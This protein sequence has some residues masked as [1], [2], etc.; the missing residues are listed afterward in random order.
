M[1]TAPSQ[2]CRAWLTSPW[3]PAG[4]LVL[5]AL[6]LWGPAVAYDFINYDDNLYVYENPFVLGGL[7]SQGWSYAWRA[8][9]GGS[10]MPLTWLSL[11]TDAAVWGARP[12]GYHLT[13]IVLHALNGLLLYLAF[14]RMTR[15]PWACA[16][17]AAIFALHPLRTESVVWI[18]ERKDVLSTFWGLLALLAYTYY[19]A[20]PAFLRYLPVL[21]AFLLALLSKPML[22]TLPVLL[23]VLDYWPLGRLRR[24]APGGGHPWRVVAEKLPLL[25]VALGVGCVTLLTQ[26]DAGAL[27]GM[28][29]DFRGRALRLADNYFFYLTR[30]FR[31][32]DLSVVYPA[33]QGLELVPALLAAAALLAIT[34]V[35]LWRWKKTPSLLSGWLWFLVALLPVIGLVPIGHIWVADRYSYLASIGL[36]WGVA[37]VLSGLLGTTPARRAVLALLAALSLAAAAGQSLRYRPVWRTSET[38]FRHALRVAPGNAVAHLNL[39]SWYERRGH[40][41]EAL[42]ELDAALS[43]DPTLGNVH[44]I[45]GNVMRGM[46]RL[47]EAVQEYQL[48]LTNSLRRAPIHSNLGIV[49]FQM[50]R[51]DAAV[52]NLQ[53]ALQMDPSLFDARFNLGLLLSH[54]RRPREAIAQLEELVRRNPRDDTAFFL[55]GNLHLAHRDPA[56]ALRSYTQALRL[57]PGRPDYIQARQQALRLTGAAAP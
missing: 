40:F 36:A 28:A 57:Q 10:W 15:R 30:F 53:Q 14:W 38:L 41:T 44:L 13:N 7:S 26:R 12:F 37:W 39:G 34:G 1:N 22:A 46:G 48:A 49:L 27:P 19:A 5:A 29:M 33:G 51:Y 32:A 24:N 17:V 4:L 42:P 56:A 3:L 47:E 23:L 16:W 18:A 21:A 2:P 11:M 35:A 55:L 54:L 20:R 8:S 25:A 43:L 52:S 6:A 45:K 50:N 9:D 31:P